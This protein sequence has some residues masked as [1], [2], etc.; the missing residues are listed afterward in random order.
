MAR[1]RKN[2]RIHL[3]EL[4]PKVDLNEKVSIDIE[5][6]RM[7][8]DRLHRP[9]GELASL[10]IG[11]GDDVYLIRE[12]KHVVPAIKRVKKGQYTK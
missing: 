10:Q 3:D 9:S 5:G 2:P 8:G 7:D 4:P 1:R 6:F 11:I 12:K